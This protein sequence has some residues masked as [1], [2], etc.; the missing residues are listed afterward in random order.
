MKQYALIGNP[1][2]HSFSKRYFTNKFEVEQIA[3]CEYELHQL[4]S[5]DEFPELLKAHANLHG[6]NVTIPY[7]ES[8]IPFLDELSEDAAEIGAVNTISINNGILKGYNTDVLGFRDSLFSW[9]KEKPKGA[10][11]LGTGGASKGIAYVLRKAEIPFLKVSRTLEK[12]NL[13]YADLDGS[14]LTN[15]S[16][17]INTTPLGTFPNVERAPDIPYNL[18]TKRNSLYDLVYNPEKTVFLNSGDSKGCQVKNGLE[19]LV[20]QAEYAWDI[21]NKSDLS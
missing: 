21:W 19:M 20:A 4:A 18:L 16:L 17:I 13:T 5:I 6:I 7:K 3:D 10:L 14:I 8:V 2:T 11:I 9:L 12:G 1:L 15:Y